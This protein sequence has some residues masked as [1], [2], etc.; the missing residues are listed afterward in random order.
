MSCQVVADIL[1]CKCCLHVKSLMI[2]I[3]G[4]NRSSI[5][6]PPFKA[7]SSCPSPRSSS[8]LIARMRY[9]LTPCPWT[10][11]SNGRWRPSATWLTPT[12]ASSTN[13]SETSCPR[14]SCTSWSTAYVS[15]SIHFFVQSSWSHVNK[16]KNAKVAVLTSHGKVM[17]ISDVHVRCGDSKAM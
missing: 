6:C 5:V 11:S 2:S 13:P 9:A 14:P 12:S 15:R 3:M 17:K 4:R 8:S 10:L 1:D 7:W 16:L